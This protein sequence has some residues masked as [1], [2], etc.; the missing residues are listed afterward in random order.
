[1]MGKFKP[2]KPLKQESGAFRS[3]Q[4]KVVLRDVDK[5]EKGSYRKAMQLFFNM[6]GQES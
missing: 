5:H 3:K 2:S 6:W 1:M 4:G